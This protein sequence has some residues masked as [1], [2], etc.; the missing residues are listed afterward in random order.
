VSGPSLARRTESSTT[1]ARRGG[2]VEVA[3]ASAKRSQAASRSAGADAD[4]ARAKTRPRL[5]YRS[6]GCGTDPVPTARASVLAGWE[7]PARFPAR[8]AAP[9]RARGSAGP[10]PARAHLV[11]V[12]EVRMAR[13]GLVAVGPGAPAGLDLK[14]ALRA[15]QCQ[16]PA[17]D[18][19]AERRPAAGDQ[20]GDVTVVLDRLDRGRAHEPTAFAAACGVVR[21]FRH[22][23]GAALS[24]DVRAAGMTLAAPAASGSSARRLAVGNWRSAP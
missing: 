7:G 20:R 21:Q 9:A 11:A 12:R 23:L 14:P 2:A 17:G 10:A 24:Q 8:S 22:R 19:I 16:R 15:H 4:G 18:L 13:G 6:N 5:R 3:P 1:H